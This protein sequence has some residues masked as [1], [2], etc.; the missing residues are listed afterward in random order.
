M[1][2]RVE[3]ELDD[4][5]FTTRMVH[6]GET[7]QQFQQHVHGTVASVSRLNESTGGLIGTVRDLTVT[8]GMARA[9][10]ENLKAVT[11]GWA[12]DIIKVN[13]EMEKLSFLLRG[14]SQAA[15]PL[16]EAANQI[17]FLRDAA[18]EAPFSLHAL[19]DKIGRAHV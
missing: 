18:K 4:G 1:S 7:V 14:M 6:A 19:T 15:D 9:A 16:K 13:A 2:I 10:F 17:T 8:L 12:G 5:S 3:I 11:T